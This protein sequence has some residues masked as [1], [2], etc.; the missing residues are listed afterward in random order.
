MHIEK[1]CPSCPPLKN[2]V[3]NHFD[4]LALALPLA[5]SPY[6]FS[7]HCSVVSLSLSLL[8]RQGSNPRPSAGYFGSPRNLF[9]GGCFIQEA[10]LFK[11]IHFSHVVLMRLYFISSLPLLLVL[12]LLFP[13]F[14]LLIWVC[15]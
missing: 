5:P 10:V 3:A 8:L 14:S 6:C 13:L 7:L 4:P 9:I 15:L 1:K 12:D 2:A 11:F